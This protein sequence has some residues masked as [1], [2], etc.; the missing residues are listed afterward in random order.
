M[1]ESRVKLKLPKI[2][3]SDYRFAIVHSKFNFDLTDDLL[4]NCCSEF[5]KLG[6]NIDSIKKWAV[7]GALEIPLVANLLAKEKSY[8]VILGIGCVIRGETSH[9]DIVVRESA[10]GLSRVS[11][12]FKIPCINGIIAAESY[13]Q[14]R[15]RCSSKGKDFAYSSVYMA[16]LMERIK[17]G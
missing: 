11:M 4:E 16:D 1:K 2:D 14:A 12:D 5:V 3:R 7:P 9:F 10:A 17:D 8:G 6:I 15:E 13:E